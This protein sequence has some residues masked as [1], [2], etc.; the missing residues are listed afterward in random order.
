MPSLEFCDKLLEGSQVAVIPGIA[1]GMDSCIRLSYAT[2][3]KTIR[4]GCDRIRK[5]VEKL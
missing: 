1:F 2:D 4:E 5:F 3:L